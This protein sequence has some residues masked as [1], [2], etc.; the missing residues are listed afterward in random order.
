MARPLIAAAGSPLSR[1]ELAAEHA[2]R[3]GFTISAY[4]QVASA[5][6]SLL[7]LIG[8]CV[9][10]LVGMWWTSRIF[11][12]PR[13]VPVQIVETTGGGDRSQLRGSGGAVEA[14]SLEDLAQQPDLTPDSLPQLIASLPTALANRKA[15]PQDLSVMGESGKT[16]ASG[17]GGGPGS[18]PGSGEGRAGLSRAERWEVRIGEGNTLTEYA[19]QL[20]FFRIEFGVIT[21][22]P[23]VN[24]VSQFSAAKP[25]LR[26]GARATEQRLYL[27]WRRGSLRQ[28]DQELVRKAGLASDGTTIVQFVPP[29]IEELLARIEF[30]FAKR[31]PHEI[32]RTLFSVRRRG[33]G[34]EFVVLEQVPLVLR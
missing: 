17:G 11:V 15:P 19:R 10:V 34:Y 2:P 16:G 14:P 29:D 22:A 4:E 5:L 32:R 27:S 26:T 8:L 18:G 6:V 23:E 24:Y 20:D 31:A 25:T 7:V 28:A 21:A 30:E 13:V 1:R 12:P 3:A 33:T 9:F